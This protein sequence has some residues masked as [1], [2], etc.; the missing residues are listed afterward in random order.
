[1]LPEC[2]HICD[3]VVV[4]DD[5]DDDDD[6]GKARSKAGGRWRKI[7]MST[8]IRL[9]LLVD[10]LGL[11]HSS[12]FLAACLTAFLPSFLPAFLPST[13][14]CV[15]LWRSRRQRSILSCIGASILDLI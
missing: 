5:D 14:P 11:L 12:P 2:I 6:D 1:V 15:Q 4:D 3:A 13:M 8:Q 9:H 7:K 10:D